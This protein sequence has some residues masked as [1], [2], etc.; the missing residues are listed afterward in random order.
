MKKLNRMTRRNYLRALSTGVLASPLLGST[1]AHGIESN[2]SD[3]PKK[4]AAILTQYRKG[5]HADVI[6]GKILRGWRY[7]D[8]PGPN[9][10]LAS[11]YIDQPNNSVLGKTLAA[12]YNVP[13]F[14]TIEDAVTLGSD[15]IAVEGVLS[16][17]EHGGYPWNEKG[18]HLYP[19]RRFFEEIVSTFEKYGKVVPVFSDKHLGPVWSDGKWI[20][21]TAM[22]KNIPLMAGSSLPLSFRNPEITVPMN[23]E[24][25]AAVGVGFSGLDIFGSH[26]LDVFQSFVERR[27]G[28]ETGVRRVQCLQADAMW[29]AV[30]NGR[31]RKDLLETVLDV[32][33]T[34]SNVDVRSL[35]RD[36]IALFLFEYND[37]F[38]GCVFML[39]GFSQGIGIAIQ[40]KGKPRPLATKIEIRQDHHHPHFAYLL[41]A[42]ERMIHTG[43]P[44][45]P[46]E[47]TLLTSG[48]LDRAL[49]SRVEDYRMID[50]PELAIEYTAVDYPYAPNPLLPS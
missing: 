10:T 2:D 26:T 40:L 23:A 5:L 13:I 39:E 47:R 12:K 1:V 41:Q 8:G 16:L 44:T 20:Y 7:D 18:Q 35:K 11:M 19:R 32:V 14:N 6:V 29:N 24:I 45:Y 37:G 28:A 30:D 48:I 42:I 31:V 43:K 33:P 21:D 15:G 4:V 3:R 36:D 46:V 9:L 17:G 34:D 49:T 50:T 27:R 22:A 38:P 25:E